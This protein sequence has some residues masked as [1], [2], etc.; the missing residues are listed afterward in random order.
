MEF[1]EG[2]EALKRRNKLLEIN[3]IN[4]LAL[5]ERLEKRNE[6]L[7]LALKMLVN[8]SPGAYEIRAIIEQIEDVPE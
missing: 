6:G 1:N 4:L 5:N 3:N 2:I 7:F 8:N